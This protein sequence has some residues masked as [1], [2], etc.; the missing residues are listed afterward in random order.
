[1]MDD[2]EAIKIIK[3]KEISSDKEIEDLKK[4]Q[5]DLVKE[6][7]QKNEEEIAKFTEEMEAEYRKFLDEQR[8]IAE[9]K[10][11]SII[12]EARQKASR[13]L[14]NISESELTKIV[15]DTVNAYLEE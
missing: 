2:I 12:E 1:M 3:E 5:D 6:A 10:A 7:S 9:D 8:K 14:L 4:T 15:I 11:K 13:I